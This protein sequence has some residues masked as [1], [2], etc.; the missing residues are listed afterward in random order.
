LVPIVA[1]FPPERPAD[2]VGNVHTA[3]SEIVQ[4]A[5]AHGGKQPA[6][7]SAIAP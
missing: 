5:L 3:D 2:S 6:R 1:T 7:L 4:F